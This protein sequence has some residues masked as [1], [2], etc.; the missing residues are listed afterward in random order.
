MAEDKG[1]NGTQGRGARGSADTSRMIETLSNNTSR[2]TVSQSASRR[3]TTERRRASRPIADQW[4]RTRGV[5]GRK[6]GA[7]GAAQIPHLSPSVSRELRTDDLMRALSVRFAVHSCPNPAC[8][9]VDQYLALHLPASVDQSVAIVIC[10]LR[11]IVK[12]SPR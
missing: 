6:E 3:L 10:L 9:I 11:Y 1:R 2:L 8:G 12:M 5:T 7:L 4:Q